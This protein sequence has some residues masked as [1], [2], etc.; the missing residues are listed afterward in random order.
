MAHLNDQD[1]DLSLSIQQLVI[2][3]RMFLVC[4][5]VDRV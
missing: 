5:L 2:G 4:G 3:L 1:P